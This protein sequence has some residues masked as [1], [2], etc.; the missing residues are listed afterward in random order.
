MI[1]D[2]FLQVLIGLL[3]VLAIA[4]GVL[5]LLRI[6]EE[7]EEKPRRQEIIVQESGWW[8]GRWSDGWPN[9][10]LGPYYSHLPVRPLLF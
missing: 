6:Q 3:A 9:R 8:P 10:P 1:L 4:L 5:L 2:V 7:R